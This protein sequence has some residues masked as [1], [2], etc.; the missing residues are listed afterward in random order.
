M[1]AKT[2]QIRVSTTTRM[3]LDGMK[4]ENPDRI[5][6]YDAAI[7]HLIDNQKIKKET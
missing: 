2:H 5:K 1:A 3:F 6:T 4:A 7:L